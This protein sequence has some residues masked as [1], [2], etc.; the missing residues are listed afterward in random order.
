MFGYIGIGEGKK[1]GAGER[2]PTQGFQ[3]SEEGRISEGIRKDLEPWEKNSVSRKE[4]LVHF[5]AEARIGFLAN[6]PV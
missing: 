4:G 6:Y 1:V 3:C 2:K 5:S